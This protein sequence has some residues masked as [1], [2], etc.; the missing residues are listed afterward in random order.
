MRS[1]ILLP[2]IGDPHPCPYTVSQDVDLRLEKKKSIKRI[3]DDNLKI[4]AQRFSTDKKFAREVIGLFLEDVI[5]EDLAEEIVHES[6][7]EGINVN[8]LPMPP[9]QVKTVT[10]VAPLPSTKEML[11]Q[12]DPTQEEDEISDDVLE[13]LIQD[14]ITEFQ[15]ANVHTLVWTTV[16]DLSRKMK[17][18]EYIDKLTKNY[19]KH[20]LDDNT[21]KMLMK[22]FARLEKE[23]DVSEQCEKIVDT[24][25][26][27]VLL[28]QSYKWNNSKK[29]TD[30]YAFNNLQNKLY[31]Q[32][33]A[34]RLAESYLT[35]MEK[36]LKT[37]DFYELK[38]NPPRAAVR[39][40]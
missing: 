34:N 5:Q 3:K 16:L 30:N 14:T 39:V 28:C 24:I 6:L 36:D 10:A 2:D 25:T 33:I 21:S 23:N 7:K 1:I 31:K 15:E 9:P 35:Q 17:L 8:K 26:F 38:E 37:P 20:L 40:R 12:T 11:V 29:I 32:S 4:T 13:D 19:K 27:D 18:Q 22:K